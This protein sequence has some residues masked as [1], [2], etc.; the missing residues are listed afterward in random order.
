MMSAVRCRQVAYF[1]E[2]DQPPPTFSRR[3]GPPGT[4]TDQGD[5]FDT[6]PPPLSDGAPF[7]KP[8]NVSKDMPGVLAAFANTRPT[9]VAYTFVLAGPSV[10]GVADDPEAGRRCSQD[11]L[12]ACRRLPDAIRS[13]NPS[14]LPCR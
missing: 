7:S 6:G 5:L 10:D 1:G 3:V 4:I 2:P 13:R 9:W 12:A 11:C 8:G 14:R